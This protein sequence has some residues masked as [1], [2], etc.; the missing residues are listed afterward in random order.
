[1]SQFNGGTADIR[2]VSYIDNEYSIDEVIESAKEVGGLIVLT[3]VIEELKQY[4]LKRAAQEQVIAIDIMGPLIEGL[5]TK[6]RTEP[7]MQP[8]L[9]R[10]L[11]EDYFKRVEAIEFAVKYD[12]GKD[13]RGIFKADVVIIGI[14]RTSKTPLSMYL[15]NQRIK[16]ANVPL[17]PEVDPSED[18][19]KVPKKKLIG[20]KI[21]PE[22]LFDIREERL[23]SLGLKIG[24]NYAKYERILEEID[25]SESIM[26]KLGC[27]VI[28][29]S[30][31]AIEETANIIID[32]IKKEGAK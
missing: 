2:K 30:N 18:L 24:A 29:V 22:N 28:N 21:N 25:Y 5:K 6:Y 20:L 16:V 15:A 26:K 10:K 8:G 31:K 13:T 1:M 9:V 3:I 14:S 19:F 27:S 11:D 17:V 7:K 32:M 4:L 23:K 12:D